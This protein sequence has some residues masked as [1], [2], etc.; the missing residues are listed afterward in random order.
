MS[1]WKK[2]I[3]ANSMAWSSYGD[4]AK[5]ALLIP[6]GPGNFRPSTGLTGKSNIKPFLPLADE[7]YTIVTVTRRR[8]MPKGYTVED[9]ANDY[10]Q[11]IAD[12]FNGQID[13]LLGVS[14]GGMIG[15]LLVANHPAS[16]RKAAILV[17]GYKVDEQSREIDLMVARAFSEKRYWTA[18]VKFSEALRTRSSLVS[19][20]KFGFLGWLVGTISPKHEHLMNDIVVEAETELTYDSRAVLPKIETPVLLVAGDEDIWFGKDNIEETVSLIPDPIVRIY[21]GRGHLDTLS[22]ERFGPDIVE[23]A[24]T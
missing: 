11:L 17:A 2:G 19:R 6:G 1:K 5:I 21:N 20:Y 8:N 24:T 23:F 22:D 9:I 7:G 16:V 10:A 14:F 4:G 12:E 3:F 15:Q 13:L 18:G